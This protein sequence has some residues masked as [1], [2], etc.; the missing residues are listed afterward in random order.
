MGERWREASAGQ[1]TLRIYPNGVAGDE[2]D[3]VR[4]MRIGKLHA[5]ALTIV[6]L[7]LISPEPQ[8][9]SVP[10]LIASNAELD[11]VRQR[12]EPFLEERL[13]AKGFVVLSWADAGWIQIFSTEPATT[14][15][16]MRKLKLFTWTGDPPSV[17]LW[18]DS[19]FRPVPLASTDILP[20]LQTGLI[21]A[22]PVTPLV[23]DAAQIFTVARHML[24]LD[25]SPLVGGTVISRSQWEKVPAEV[26]PRLLAIA[27]EVS[28]ELVREVR[29]LD[30]EAVEAMRKRGLKV[31]EV[32]RE[33]AAEWRQLA[34]KAYPR[35]RTQIV[36]AE[37]FDRVKALR[38]EFRAGPS[39]AAGAAR[40]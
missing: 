27:R 22:V 39:G 14:P 40:P 7:S 10:Y 30:Q 34:E 23:A 38:D 9:L 16:A 31:Y 18:R 11:Y 36:D 35:I 4:A 8:A 37:T 15:D 29:R 21:Q 32:D 26:R 3:M 19:G 17:E 28:A 12:L 13:A 6:G 25:W 1:V 33:Q 20:S 24:R 2:P 5:A